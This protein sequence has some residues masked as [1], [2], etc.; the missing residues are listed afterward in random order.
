MKN[1]MAE[2]KQ[3]TKKVL[4]LYKLSSGTYNVRQETQ[5]LYVNKIP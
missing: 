5:S 1:S 3:Y 2:I 4:V